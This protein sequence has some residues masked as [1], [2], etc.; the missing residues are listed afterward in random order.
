MKFYYNSIELEVPDGIYYPDEDSILLAE[1]IQQ[2]FIKNKDVLEVGCGS[3]LVAILLAQNN[4][5]TAL[6][7]NEEAVKATEENAK[8]NNAEINALRSDLFKNVKQKFDIII[9]N[10]PYLPPSDMD[11]YLGKEKRNLIDDNVIERFLGQLS[12]YLNKEGFALLVTSSLTK[13]N[14]QDKEL[15][16]EVIASKKLPWEEL[17]VFKITTLQ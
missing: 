13:L 15:R 14:M 3:G 4:K 9:F 16:I 10:A 7:I 17:K 11:K 5:V 8:A 1:T 2:L 6:D 12:K